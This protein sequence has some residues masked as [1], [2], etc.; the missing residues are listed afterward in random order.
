MESQIPETEIRNS[1]FIVRSSQRKAPRS[2]GAAAAFVLAAPAVP[3]FSEKKLQRQ[4][5]KLTHAIYKG[6][7]A[8]AKAIMAAAPFCRFPL[9][10]TF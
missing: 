5:I 3:V 1:G 7:E 9:A 4:I 6:N 2:V 8:Y 10:L